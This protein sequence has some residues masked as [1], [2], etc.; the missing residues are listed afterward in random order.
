MYRVPIHSRQHPMI[1]RLYVM[2][3]RN[4][5]ENRKHIINNAELGGVPHFEHD[6][7]LFWE[8][9]EQLSYNVEDRASVQAKVCVPH[10]GVLLKPPKHHP[11]SKYQSSLMYYK[12]C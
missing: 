6:D 8:K 3:W 7:N 4:D 1:P 12:P 10:R 2:G 5:M 11:T 9:K